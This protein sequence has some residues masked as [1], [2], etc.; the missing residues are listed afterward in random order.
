[1]N[2]LSLTFWAITAVLLVVSLSSCKKYPEE[3]KKLCDS[4]AQEGCREY[5]ELDTDYAS[6]EKVSCEIAC[7]VEVWLKCERAMLDTIPDYDPKLIVEP[8]KS[9]CESSCKERCQD[10]CQNESDDPTDMPICIHT[11]EP[12]CVFGCVKESKSSASE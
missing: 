7:H 5:C 9:A 12:I 6:H 8:Y 10:L 11:C 4:I 1:M 2:K 3:I